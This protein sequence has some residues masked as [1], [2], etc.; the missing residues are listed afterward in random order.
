MQLLDAEEK[1]WYCYHDDEVWFEK[2]GKWKDEIDLERLIDT[3][4]FP[5][6]Y[7]ELII[8][9][10]AC[11]TRMGLLDEDERRW[12]CP[13][14]GEPLIDKDNVFLQEERTRLMLIQEGRRKLDL[15]GLEEATRRFITNMRLLKVPYPQIEDQIKSTKAGNASPILAVIE[16][17]HAQRSSTQ[18]DSSGSV[19]AGFLLGGVVGM[20][21]AASTAPASYDYHL[22][23]PL[24]G[25]LPPQQQKAVADHMTQWEKW[26]KDEEQQR[27]ALL[28]PPTPWFSANCPT[29]GKIMTDQGSRLYCMRDDVLIHK[30]TGF[31]M[32]YP[33][34]AE[35]EHFIDNPVKVQGK[36]GNHLMSLDID[37]LVVTDQDGKMEF[38]ILLKDLKSCSV[39]DSGK[40][41]QLAI[42]DGQLS[43][44]TD[45]AELWVEK[46]KQKNSTQD[47]T[48]VY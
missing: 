28:N 47:I 25:P 14:C 15:A 13:K 11:G 43:I 12:W 42:T 8:F 48:R 30:A 38:A 19:I 40:L 36:K 29:C 16:M 32:H 26:K 21:I 9:C 17:E 7:K 35:W 3:V 24:V 31:P 1:R 2:L 44:Q 6:S 37:K 45:N 10:N 4:E 22:L 23:V 18:T 46:L 27:L 33:P 39:G 34:A 41:L 20:A 5:R